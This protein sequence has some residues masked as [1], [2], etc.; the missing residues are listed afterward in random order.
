[1]QNNT[2]VMLY[3]CICLAKSNTIQ[4]SSREVLFYCQAGRQH[5]ENKKNVPV[6][7]DLEKYE[8]GWL[9]LSIPSVIK[10]QPT[11]VSEDQFTWT[12]TR[13]LSLRRA[14]PLNQSR[15]ISAL[16]LRW[17]NTDSKE[18]LCLSRSPSLSIR[19]SLTA[20]RWENCEETGERESDAEQA[21]L[22][23]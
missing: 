20:K 6:V 11:L 14:V 10:N 4:P 18:F 7:K 5:D 21:V 13:C 23:T 12:C 8:Q 1:M 15:K 16:A 19:Q 2:L 22:C 9:I 3:S 17:I